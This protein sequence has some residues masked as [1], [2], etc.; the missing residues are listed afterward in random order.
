MLNFREIVDLNLPWVVLVYNLLGDLNGL[1]IFVVIQDVVLTNLDD[2]LS[3]F[4][5]A[6]DTV[7]SC[8][9][10]VLVDNGTTTGVTVG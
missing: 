9:D 1:D 3:K 5:D 10:P 4:G 6:G 8:E 2:C 7:T